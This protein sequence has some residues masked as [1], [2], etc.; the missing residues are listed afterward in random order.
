MSTPSLFLFSYLLSWQRPSEIRKFLPLSSRRKLHF[1]RCSETW[2]EMCV[3]I[4]VPL[5]LF[6]LS[7]SP[8]LIHETMQKFLNH[9]GAQEPKISYFKVLIEYMVGCWLLSHGFL[10][11]VPPSPHSTFWYWGWTSANDISLLSAGSWLGSAYQGCHRELEGGK[12]EW[13]LSLLFASCLYSVA[14]A[15]LFPSQQPLV[16]AA[17]VVL[18]CCPS[19]FVRTNLIASARKDSTSHRCSCS[20][21]RVPALR[22]LFSG[23][24]VQSPSSTGA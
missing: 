7:G 12:T 14:P 4:P 11:P 18:V 16:S 21:V 9:R 1:T 24:Q 3:L 10:G 5:I 19:L 20:G 13:R 17:Q 6:T 23:L 22:S 2:S 15:T 8:F